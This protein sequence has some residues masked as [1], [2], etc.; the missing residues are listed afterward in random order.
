MSLD[1]LHEALKGG[2]MPQSPP[3]LQRYPDLPIPPRY[4]VLPAEHKEN[5]LT[6]LFRVCAY[7]LIF[8]G[9]VLF[10]VAFFY[11]NGP[12]LGKWCEAIFNWLV[13][14]LRL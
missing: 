1:E 5:F 8:V 14:V 12:L 4:V 11:A 10:L 6:A 9:S 13:N 2:Q 7:G 3:D